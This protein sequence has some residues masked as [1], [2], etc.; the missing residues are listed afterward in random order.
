MN[1]YTEIIAKALKIDMNTAKNVQ[2]FIECWF[3]DFRWS[4]ATQAK[5]ARTAKEAY[6]M[7]QNPKYAEM[8]KMA[9]AN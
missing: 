9:E 7:M 6:A 2:S 3:D 4:S 1:L 5:I 8:T